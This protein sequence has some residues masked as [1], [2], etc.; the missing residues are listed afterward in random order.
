MRCCANILLAVTAIYAAIFLVDIWFDIIPFYIFYKITVT[1]IVVFLGV[2]SWLL[3]NRWFIKD[4]KLKRNK[5]V[6]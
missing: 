2:L 6:D 4:E 5:F 3:I 1:F